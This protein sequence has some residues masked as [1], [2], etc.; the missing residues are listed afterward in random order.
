MCVFRVTSDQ[1]GLRVPSATQ[2]FDMKNQRTPEKQ[3]GSKDG[4]VQSSLASEQ[5]WTRYLPSTSRILAS[6]HC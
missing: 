3:I 6:D 1:Y 4:L 2:K 5:T